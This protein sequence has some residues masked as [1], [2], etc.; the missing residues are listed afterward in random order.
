MVIFRIQQSRAAAALL[1][2]EVEDRDP[3][4]RIDAVMMNKQGDGLIAIEGGVGD[5]ASRMK[6]VPLAQALNTPVQECSQRVETALQ[7]PARNL[8]VTPQQEP[9]RAAGQAR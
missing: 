1:T 5:P 9:Q 4:R 7:D 6:L 3:L 8:Q 2:G